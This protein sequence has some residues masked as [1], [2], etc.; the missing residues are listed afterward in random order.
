[1]LTLI[2]VISFLFLA[3]LSLS[4]LF[5]EELSEDDEDDDD[6]EDEEELLLKS[7]LVFELF[8]RLNLLCSELFIFS[9]C[10]IDVSE[11][12]EFDRR[13]EFSFDLSDLSDDDD[14]LSLSLDGRLGLEKWFIL[15]N[16]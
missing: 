15:F 12:E 10:R 6:D 9:S 16:Y 11:Y 13:G 7:G 2:E 14:R 3:S 1:M 4:S 8:G 5:S